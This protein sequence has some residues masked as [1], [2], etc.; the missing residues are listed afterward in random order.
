MSVDKKVAGQTAKQDV[1]AF[2]GRHAQT[3]GGRALFEER[4]EGVISIEVKQ[5][6]TVG[7]VRLLGGGT[8][9]ST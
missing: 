5:A 7:G 1:D 3:V 2:G 9:P 8:E 6:G 4:V